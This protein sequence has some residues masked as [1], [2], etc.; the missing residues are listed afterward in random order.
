MPSIVINFWF[1]ITLL[2]LGGDW[3]GNSQLEQRRGYTGEYLEARDISLYQAT[4]AVPDLVVMASGAAAKRHAARG[5]KEDTNTE[6]CAFGRTTTSRD[7][8]SI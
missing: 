8:S 7:G 2:F 5:S 1:C 6:E 3:Q 4:R